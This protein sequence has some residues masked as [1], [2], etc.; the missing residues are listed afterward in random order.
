[1]VRHRPVRA[2]IRWTGEPVRFPGGEAMKAALRRRIRGL[3]LACALALALSACA[4]LKTPSEAIRTR[5]ERREPD[6]YLASLLVLEINTDFGV[7]LAVEPQ[8]AVLPAGDVGFWV[9]NKWTGLKHG[10]YTQLVRVIGPAGKGVVAERSTEL[11]VESGMLAITSADPILLSG[12]EPGIYQISVRLDG[13]EAAR[14]SFE[15]V[16][17]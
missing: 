12:A 10:R 1:M 5:P 17:P 13:V 3:L 14:Y 9:L 4:S 11:E 6:P 8:T 2:Y 16:A 7:A 15:L